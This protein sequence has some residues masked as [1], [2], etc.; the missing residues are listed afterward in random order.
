MLH[1]NAFNRTRDRIK[2]FTGFK[3]KQA[4]L[5]LLVG[6]GIF[7]FIILLTKLYARLKD[8]KPNN[9]AMEGKQFLQSMF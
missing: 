9:L 2:R 5:Y 6:L 1:S 4:A 8:S 7:I 3:Q